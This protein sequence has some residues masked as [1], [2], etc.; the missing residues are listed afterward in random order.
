MESLT[1]V[2]R[3]EEENAAMQENISDLLGLKEDGIV[4]KYDLEKRLK[5]QVQTVDKMTAKEKVS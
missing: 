4:A 5:A 1:R 2:V 3:L